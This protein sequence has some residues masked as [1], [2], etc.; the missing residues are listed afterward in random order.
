MQASLDALALGAQDIAAGRSPDVASHPDVAAAIRTAARRE[1]AA[2]VR[3]TEREPPSLLAFLR[4][5]YRGAG[6]V[7]SR[8][9]GLRDDAGELASRD[10]RRLRPGL[11]SRDGMSL[12]DATLAA[13]EA[14]YLGSRDGKRPTPDDLLRAIDEELAGSKVYSAQDAA[15][16][17]RLQGQ[18]QAAADFDDMEYRRDEARGVL[19]DMGVRLSDEQIDE[20]LTRYYAPGND[21]DL[22]DIFADI[23]EA[24]AMMNEGQ[25]L[26]RAAGDDVVVPFAARPRPRQRAG[27]DSRNPVDPDL[28]PLPP[29]RRQAD[30]AE[31][32]GIDAVDQ[33]TMDRF[34]AE[35]D[36]R[37]LIPDD[38]RAEL[39][40][41]AR[42]E[43]QAARATEAYERAAWCVI[44]A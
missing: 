28:D 20:G 41:A 29:V 15:A 33:A 19:D 4:R 9:G 10:L 2:S 6:E 5:P 23:A 31:A 35:L 26:P 30:G 40:E 18:R 36:E 17:E 44:A 24:D 1:I 25:A 32:F 39:D 7:L 12:D 27:F 43:A 3:V 21:R 13:W 34:V 22:E 37:G 14:G 16:V 11:V 8:I 42:L 38:I